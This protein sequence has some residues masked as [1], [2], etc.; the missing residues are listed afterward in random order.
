MAELTV[1]GAELV[2][3]MT[4]LEKVESVHGEIRV[5]VASVT[6]VEVLDDAIDAVHGFRVGTRVPGAVAVGTFTARD[7]KTFAVVHHDTPRG[8][9]VK[10]TDDRFDQLIVGCDDP[11]SVAALLRR[12]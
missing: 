1:E 2:L 3:T 5:P 9:L 6:G 4:K 8:V 7:A 10:L 12:K 11:E